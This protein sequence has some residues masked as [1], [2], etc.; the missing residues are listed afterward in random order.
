MGLFDFFKK[1]K[2]FDDLPAGISLSDDLLPYWPEFKK[3]ALEFISIEA[4]PNNSLG[5]TQ[6]KFAGLPYLP[7]GFPYPKDKDGKYMFPLAQINFSEVPSLDG[8]PTKGI[9]Q[10]YIS[11]NDIYGL[12]LDDLKR[13]DSFR[14][15][16][17][18][19]VDEQKAQ[20]E[21][22]FLDDVVFENV[23]ISEQMELNFSKRVDYAG[24][25]DVRFRKNFGTSFYTWTERF[26]KKEDAIFDEV[27]ETFNS[28][29]NKIGGYAD[30]TQE[31]PR[32][33]DDEHEDWI[34]LLQIASQDENIMWGD[35]GICN[36]FIHPDDLVKR[37]FSKVMY[38]WDCT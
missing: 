35:F 12:N 6:S 1:K 14:V 11:S 33:Y 38:H 16:Y 29:G 19:T 18:E 17:F 30:F 4:K 15:L 7:E 21:L 27:S 28:W 8:Y 37:D 23:P 36:F 24:V 3:T 10:F 2:S 22:P 5:V 9:L 32:Y 13:Q 20:K 34:L 25:S 31:D 26:G